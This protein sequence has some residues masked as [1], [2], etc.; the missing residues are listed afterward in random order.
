VTD[1]ELEEMSN[2]DLINELD[3]VAATER[4]AATRDQDRETLIHNLRVHQVELEMQNRELREAHQRVEEATARYSDLYDFAPVGYCTLLSDGKIRELNLTAATLLGAQSE[5]LVGNHFSAVAPLKETRHF[6]AHMRQCLAGTERV[7]SELT[8]TADKLEARTIQI[9]SEPDHSQTGAK[10][11]Y[12]TILVDISNLKALENRL[13]LLSTA[14]ERLTSSVGYG[15]AIEAAARIVVPALC[16]ICMIDVVTT[17]DTVERKVVLFADPEKQAKL[18]ERMMHLKTRPGWQTPQ[19][20]VVASGESMLISEVA[21]NMHGWVSDDDRDGD[22]MR[23]AGVGSLMVVP[24]IARGRTLGALTLAMAESERRYSLLDLQV[25]QDL[26]SR[27]AVALDN[28]RLYQ[29]AEKAIRARDELLGVVAHDLRNPLGNILLQLALLQR[30]SGEKER[31]SLKPTEA[32]ARAANRMDRLIQDLLDIQRVDAGGICV[33]PISLPVSQVLHEFA[34]AQKP[35]IL[36]KSLELRLEVGPDLSEVLADRN[37]LLQVLENL[38]GNATKFTKPGGLLTVG[39][40]PHDRG[41]LF[42][43]KDTGVGIQSED[44]PHLFDRFW[45]AH[46]A[47]KQGVGLGLP[48]VKGIVEAHGGQVWVES[49]TGRGSTFF[50]TLPRA[51]VPANMA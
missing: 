51:D 4:R 21:A 45:Q 47:G 30:P 25:A 49:V 3:Q 43:V 11:T 34:E 8:F 29:I 13:R 46:Q 24:L 42:W 35:L 7:T 28:A 32:I 17:S 6:H 18:A 36:S 44:L 19:S 14:G 1:P 26:S 22:T 38:V 2:E 39:A 41:L 9:I 48:I 27:F 15:Q 12:R 50:F 20:S 23:S 16:D 31:R 33:E 37:R 10:T 40:A 5:T